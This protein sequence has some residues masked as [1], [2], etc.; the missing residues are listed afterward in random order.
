MPITRISDR[1]T[2]VGASDPQLPYFDRL[3]PTPYGTTYNSYLIQGDE[4]IALIDPVQENTVDQLLRNLAAAGIDRL[5]DLICLHTEQ[6]HSGSV[7]ILCDRFPN[8]RLIGTAKVAEFMDVHHHIPT[9]RFHEVAAGDVIDLGGVTL[10]C[11]PIA[12]A[13]WPDNTMFWMPG[14][15]ILF[16]SDLFGSHYAP[17]AP[18]GPDPA[19]QLKES[20]AY[21][22]EIMMPATRHVA[23]YVEQVRAL[24]PEIICAAHGPVWTDPE[25]I[26]AQYEQMVSG[27]VARSVVIAYVSM[28]ESTAKMVD[29]VA[30]TLAEEG[31]DVTLFDLGD[32]GEDLRVHLGSAVTASVNAAALLLAAPTVLGGAHPVAQAMALMLNA[33]RPPVRWI[34]LLGSFGW[35]SQMVK[36]LEG[37]MARHPAERLDPLL[38]R[39]L[40]TAEEAADLRAYA[41]ALAERIYAIPEDEIID[42]VIGGDVVG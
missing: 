15:K 19:I 9:E 4:R 1:V 18:G 23:R 36:Q 14:E 6:D 26:L 2:S 22:S 32:A 25:P 11:K 41:E 39:G 10:E 12:F 33:F 34:G 30:D 16:S 8:V 13:H 7:D 20:R 21:F 28:H 37:L 31:L 17:T 5:D 40:P 3:M 35:G 42:D 27:H 24:N 29:I 38:V